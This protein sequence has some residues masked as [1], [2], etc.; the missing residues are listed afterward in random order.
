M[1]LLIQLHLI[2]CPNQTNIMTNLILCLDIG[3]TH[4]TAG[5]FKPTADNIEEVAHA[6]EHV[7]SM[8][9]KDTILKQWGTAIR[10]ILLDNTLI[11]NIYV[12]IPGPFDYEH[13]ISLMDGMH[14]YQ[15]LLNFDVRE[16]L[17]KEFAVNPRA[18]KFFN[19]AQA[20]LLGEIYYANFYD[21][22]VI[23]LTLGTGL[24]SAI[25]ENNNVYDLNYGSVRFR[26]GIAEDYISTRGI[27]SHVNSRYNTSI[28]NVKELVI[29]GQYKEEKKLAFEFL[30][31][32]LIDF[33]NEHLL[34][35]NPNYIIIG[36]SIAKA[37]DYFFYQLKSSVSIP[38]QLASL[39]ELN[40]FK[41]M[42]I[43]SQMKNNN[44]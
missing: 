8:G 19:D 3:G 14:K 18:I 16:F 32:S 12:S 26:S 33:I 31:E 11:T 39:D 7:D 28:E 29:N 42:I 4:I 15:A 21:K 6:R 20:F 41:G 44:L 38:I 43:Y 37:S 30:T 34:P 23:G 24:G 5:L 35:H 17:S 9:D 36:G 25:Y 2:H 13:G 1:I 22:K 40:V 10:N 27:I